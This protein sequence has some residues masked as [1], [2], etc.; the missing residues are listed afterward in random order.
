MFAP[1]QHVVLDAHDH[2]AYSIDGCDGLGQIVAL[3]HSNQSALVRRLHVIDGHTFADEDFPSASHF[4]EMVLL[5]TS[6]PAVLITMAQIK[7]VVHVVTVLE[8]EEGTLV[9]DERHG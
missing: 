5:P 7:H 3:N 1:L 6:N 4:K 2:V 8:I 9:L